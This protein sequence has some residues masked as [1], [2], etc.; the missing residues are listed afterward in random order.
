MPELNAMQEQAT[1]PRFEPKA[2]GRFTA[3]ATEMPTL[4]LL[5]GGLATRMRPVT[6][7]IAKS[8]LPVAG[9]PFIEHQLRMLAGQAISHVVI[10]CGH[11]EEQIRAHVGDG[12]AFGCSVDYSADGPH[13]L[14]TG[15][16][17][18][19]A[20]PLLGERFLV[21]YGDSFLPVAIAPVWRSFIESGKQALMTVHHNGD[22]W[23]TSNVE[24]AQGSIVSYS[25][26]TRTPRM[27]YIDYGLNCLSA[28]V[29]QHWP[30]GAR[31]DLADVTAMLVEQGELAG[32][33]VRERFY[34]IG[35]PAGL[36]ET[37]ALLRGSHGKREAGKGR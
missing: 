20:L 32:F 12:S 5:A 8:M 21:M 22:R 11:L 9:L 15:G 26:H 17:L 14:G 36:A 29:L 6:T 19:K 24:F 10:C 27:R 35:S 13:P 28:E 4:A 16:A 34:E 1:E 18:R 3:P 25:K 30:A 7:T 23:D 2:S 37:D 31:F 33:E